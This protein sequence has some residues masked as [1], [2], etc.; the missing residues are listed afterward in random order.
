VKANNNDFDGFAMQNLQTT[1]TGATPGLPCHLL[2][3]A[4]KVRT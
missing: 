2:A 4:E 1:P 3:F